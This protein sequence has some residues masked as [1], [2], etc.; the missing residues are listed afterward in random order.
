[1]RTITPWNGYVIAELVETDTTTQSGLIVK[2]NKKSLQ[3]A[4]VVWGGRVFVAGTN[5]LFNSELAQDFVFDDKKY[6]A[7]DSKFVIGSFSDEKTNV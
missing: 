4:K 5:I 7:L 3:T 6:I 2:S 1:M